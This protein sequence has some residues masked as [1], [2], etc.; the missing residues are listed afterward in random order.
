MKLDLNTKEWLA[1]YALLERNAVVD[2]H[3]TE[4]QNRMRKT[5]TELLNN[6]EKAQIQQWFANTT[7]KIGRLNQDL[8][9]V[10]AQSSEMKRFIKPSEVLTDDEEPRQ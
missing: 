6:A 3:L 4:V 8:Q 7:E 10:V 5:L 9:Q 2:K 1:I